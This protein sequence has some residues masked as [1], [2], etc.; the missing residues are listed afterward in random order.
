MKFLPSPQEDDEE[1]VATPTI[2]Y[3]GNDYPEHN[4]SGFCDDLSHECHENPESIDELN[5][6][7]QEG[8]ITPGDA[9]RIYRGKTVI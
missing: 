1:Y 3:E 5:D 6:A 9:D 8:E 2:P 7:I 4:H